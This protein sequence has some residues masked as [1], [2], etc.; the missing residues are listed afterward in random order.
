[1]GNS[2]NL[3]SIV[4]YARHN[5]KHVDQ[6]N[7]AVVEGAVLI[8]PLWP[9]LIKTH[10]CVVV[11]PPWQALHRRTAEWYQHHI[12]LMVSTGWV[13]A[14]AAWAARA[15]HTPG[16]CAARGAWAPNR[17]L[18][19]CG[20]Q[21]RWICGKV[22]WRRFLVPRPRAFFLSPWAWKEGF[23]PKVMVRGHLIKIK[24]SVFLN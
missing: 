15:C 8:Q 16:A 1:M 12:L 20:A 6:Q 4:F 11:V 19:V 22:R 23:S 10:L 21:E 17:E 2:L 24:R 7:H 5:P 18:R 9:T 3:F 13:S 14:M